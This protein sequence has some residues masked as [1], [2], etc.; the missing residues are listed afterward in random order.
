MTKVVKYLEVE[1]GENNT[2]EVIN[3]GRMTC[4]HCKGAKRFVVYP[5]RP[6]KDYESCSFC[7]G[8]GLVEAV[9]RISYYKIDDEQVGRTL[10]K[11]ITYKKVDQ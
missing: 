11:E 3:L 2:E 5:P 7:N 1:P 8:T 9:A 6:G 10:T 4:G